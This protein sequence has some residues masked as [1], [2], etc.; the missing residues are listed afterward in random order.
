MTKA[1]QSATPIIS[2]VDVCKHYRDG[3]VQA[4]DGV[5]M[6]ILPGEFLSVMGPSGSGKST[7]LNVVGALDRPTS[8][9]VSFRGQ[10][11]DRQTNLD[12]LR[13]HEI[14]F[15]FQ[16]FY[17]LP[18]LTARENV[19]IPMFQSDRSLGERVGEAERLL[20]LVSLQDRMDH[21]P[22]QLSNGQRQRVAIARS[23]ANGPS[24]VLADEPTG[25]LDSESG[26]EV[27]ELFKMLNDSRQTTLVI[28][29]HDP[30]IAEKTKRTVCLRDGRLV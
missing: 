20:S 14:G 24:L 3:D 15:V 10:T 1:S 4:L 2:L 9:T 12:R 21:L 5:S 11:I 17:L 29:T 23:L 25:A 16:S 26:V 7:L 22:K 27:M 19:Q 6:E 8:G 13:S 30:A 28:V 18:N